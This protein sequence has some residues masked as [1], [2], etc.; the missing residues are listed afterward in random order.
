MKMKASSL[1]KKKKK[2]VTKAL[3][4]TDRRPEI[5]L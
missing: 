3:E 4:L 1:F 2:K 5:W